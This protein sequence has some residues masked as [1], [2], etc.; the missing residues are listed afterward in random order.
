MKRTYLILGIL[1]TLA[2]MPA[3]SS[4]KSIQTAHALP[5]RRPAEI[6]EN[7]NAIQARIKS[8]LLDDEEIRK[9]SHINVNVFNGA[10]LLTGEAMSEGIK[11]K[12]IEMARIVPHVTMIHDYLSVDYPSDN[13]SRANDRRITQSIRQAL[14]QIHATNFDATLVKVITEQS[15]VYLMGRLHREEGTRVVNI[16]RLE[17]DIRQVVTVFDYMD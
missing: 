16:A 8:D 4:K 3:C 5:D 13:L 15:T 10:V 12:I 6:I 14:S 2:L 11:N 1:S 9:W 17:P 7:D